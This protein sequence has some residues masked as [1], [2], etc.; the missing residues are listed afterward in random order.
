MEAPMS[1]GAGGAGPQPPHPARRPCLGALAL[2]LCSTPGPPGW[3]LQGQSLT[4]LNCSPEP[5]AGWLRSTPQAST[6]RA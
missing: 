2:S 4:R 1:A 6:R 5:G 3:P